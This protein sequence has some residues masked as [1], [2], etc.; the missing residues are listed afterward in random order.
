MRW[1]QLPDTPN[2]PGVGGALA[3]TSGDFLLMAGGSNFPDKPLWE[4]GAKAWHDTVYALK[5]KAKAWKAV[6]KL[7]KPIGYGV[8]ISIRQG[9][10]CI[11]GAD[12]VRHHADC[13]VL[14]LG[15]EGLR[16]DSFP[17]LPRPLAYAAGALV[18][19]K[20]IVA[21]GTERP[22]ATS[23]SSAAFCIDLANLNA[24]WKE[25]PLWSGSGRMLA[26]A[27]GTKDSFY[28]FGGL[29]LKPGANG[30]AEREYLSDCHAFRLGQ[31]WRRLADLPRP[32]AAAATPCPVVGP[33]VALISGDDGSKAGKFKP[34]EH[35]GFDKGILTYD[36]AADS[37]AASGEAPVGRVTLPCAKWNGGF[38]LVNGEI[39]PGRRSAECWMAS[40]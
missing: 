8:A 2:A 40:A 29:A 37:W 30:A 33:I 20:V 3:G 22:D 6:G 36:L 11:G 31:D 9:L 23:A 12:A 13:H 7:P 25:L 5:P 24:G 19:S 1:T 16:V 35:P 15:D 18:G 10:L 14:S 27:A 17:A 34:A 21:G 32:V 28:L 39:G 4:G 26:Q 38:V